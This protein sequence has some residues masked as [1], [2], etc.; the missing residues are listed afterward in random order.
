MENKSIQISYTLL[1]IFFVITFLFSCS[2][3]VNINELNRKL[4]YLEKQKNEGKIE[5]P[6][7]EDKLFKDF[8][9]KNLFKPK[10]T[11]KNYDE[12]LSERENVYKLIEKLDSLYSLLDDSYANEKIAIKNLMIKYYV[13]L[14]QFAEIVHKVD[15]SCPGPSSGIMLLDID[16]K[17]FNDTIIVYTRRYNDRDLERNYMK[18]TEEIEEIKKQFKQTPENYNNNNNNNYH[19]TCQ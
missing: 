6:H 12:M 7:S 17:K 5:F 14:Y 9:S 10:I 3:E 15:P 1:F 8:T 18:A 4:S 13:E 19:P 11:T 16:F 2:N